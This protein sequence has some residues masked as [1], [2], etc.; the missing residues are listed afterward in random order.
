MVRRFGFVKEGSF[1]PIDFVDTIN[2]F[3]LGPNVALRE[4]NRKKAQK[5][6]DRE[7]RS[8]GGFPF[9]S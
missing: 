2:V 7:I 8:F 4:S 1:D 5:Q 3:F 9:G 6:F